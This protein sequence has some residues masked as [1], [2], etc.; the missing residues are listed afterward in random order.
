MAAT[1][2]I[3]A[4]ADGKQK[5]SKDCF[6]EIARRPLHGR[7]QSIEQLYRGKPKESLTPPT[8]KVKIPT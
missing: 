5:Q 4:F 7:R 8:D 6:Y 2:W 1:K 3:P